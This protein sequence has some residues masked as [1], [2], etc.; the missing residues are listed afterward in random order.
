MKRVLSLTMAMMMLFST[1]VFAATISDVQ[2]Q[3]VEKDAVTEKYS[4][5]YSDGV[6]DGNEYLLWA[7]DGVYTD[8][9][10]V[11]FTQE[12]VMYI[13]QATAVSNQVSFT[14]F[15]PKE[16][17]DATLLITGQGMD[18]P[19]IIGYIAG[20]SVVMV[21]GDVTQD[22]V[23]N[24]DDVVKLLR[25]VLKAENITDEAALQAAEVTGN[26]ELNMDDVVK[27]LRYVLH[28]DDTLD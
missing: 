12:K 21:K 16:E 24:M 3:V 20:K 13:N 14:N 27:L 5:T 19:E 10:D 7:I 23:V 8:V 1:T 9:E 11:S 4:V 25:H 6:T 18:A 2:D 17:V 22:T 28:A 26:D 15:L